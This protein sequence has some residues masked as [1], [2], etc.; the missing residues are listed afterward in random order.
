MTWL[1]ETL[2][3]KFYFI[4]GSAIIVLVIVG[5]WLGVQEQKQW[6]AFATAH[7]CKVTAHKEGYYAYSFYN[8]TY[9]THYVPSTDTYHCNDGVDY[10]R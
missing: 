8:G 10:T 2:M 1:I 6:D 9:A 5:I 4:I 3:D 7:D